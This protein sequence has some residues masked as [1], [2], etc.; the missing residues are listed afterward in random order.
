M[1]Y[2]YDEFC[3]NWDE[4]KKHILADRLGKLLEEFGFRNVQGY[5]RGSFPYTEVDGNF[6]GVKIRRITQLPEAKQKELV[7]RADEIYREVMTAKK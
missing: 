4:S 2:G 1:H 5:E 6:G 3:Q 7:K